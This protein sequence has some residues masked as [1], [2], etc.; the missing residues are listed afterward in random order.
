MGESNYSEYWADYPRIAKSKEASVQ[1]A[2]G[3]EETVRGIATT[4]SEAL[5]PHPLEGM[6]AERFPVPEEG[7]N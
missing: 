5:E 6:H 1:S 2:C 4:D 3:Y 7:A